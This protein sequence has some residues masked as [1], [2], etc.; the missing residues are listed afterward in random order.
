MKYDYVISVTFK[1]TILCTLTVLTAK[2]SWQC[3]GNGFLLPS[4]L[5]SSSAEQ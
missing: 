5:V 4:G 2:K 1:F 3:L